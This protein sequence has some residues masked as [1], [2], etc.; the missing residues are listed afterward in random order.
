M[1]QKLKLPKV[2]LTEEAIVLVEVQAII[3]QL[4]DKYRSHEK[5]APFIDATLSPLDAILALYV[6]QLTRLYNKELKKLTPIERQAAYQELSMKAEHVDVL[7]LNEHTLTEV[8]QSEAP[9]D[10]AKQIELAASFIAKLPTMKLDESLDE[11]LAVFMHPSFLKFD[12]FGTSTL[13]V[14]KQLENT[15][16]LFLGIAVAMLAV[17]GT[18]HAR[19]DLHILV[20][21]WQ[22]V[23]NQRAKLQLD[24]DTLRHHIGQH[25]A[26]LVEFGNKLDAEQAKVN[27]A[28][29]YVKQAKERMYSDFNITR[30]DMEITDT[31]YHAYYRRYK[32]AEREVEALQQKNEVAPVKNSLFSK[33]TSKVKTT[34]NNVS[35]K[36]KE[37]EKKKLYEAMVDLFITLDSRYLANEKQEIRKLQQQVDILQQQKDA[38]EAERVP[39]EQAMK[40]LQQKITDKEKA[41]AHMERIFYS[42]DVGTPSAPNAPRALPAIEA[43]QLDLDDVVLDEHKEEQ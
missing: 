33:L 41:I 28:T 19:A 31:T 1:V 17:E 4:Y 12:I 7:T 6:V 11:V 40:A 2:P 39:I 42:I 15:R 8:L 26:L 3:E 25:E 37:R 16:M 22:H 18:R 32:E 36:T 35:I 13:S 14:S 29:Y 5:A 24:I 9:G 21:H 20:A 10:Y 27:E 38:I 23:V 30:A 34:A 43:T